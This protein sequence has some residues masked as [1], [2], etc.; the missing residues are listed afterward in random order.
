MITPEFCRTMARYNAW[1]N[2]SLQV[3]ADG[4]AEDARRADRGA[5]FGSIFGTLNHLLWADTIWMSRFDG[6]RKPKGGI[7]DSP[8][9]TSEWVALKAARG[10]ADQRIKT[11]ARRLTEADLQGDLAWFSGA[12]GANVQKS[13]GFCVQHFFNHQTHHRGQVH[14]MLTAAGAKPADTDLFIM[15]EDA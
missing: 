10:D 13:Y 9:F 2:K 7:S 6:W 3:A 4:L 12:L 14:A 8:R 15:P 5:F 1:Q 11:W